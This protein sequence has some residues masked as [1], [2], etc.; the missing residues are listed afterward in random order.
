MMRSC[1]PLAL[2]LLL[3]AVDAGAGERS[4]LSS[5]PVAAPD[6]PV[7]AG[8][9]KG[10]PGLTAKETPN[11]RWVE[12]K[13]ATRSGYCLVSTASGMHLTPSNFSSPERDDVLWRLVESDGKAKLERTRFEL[14]GA[15][16]LSATTRATTELAKVAS[17]GGVTVWAF[18]E[19]SGDVVLLVSGENASGREA[20]GIPR[21]D[22]PG[23]PTV[24]SSCGF[25][26]TRLSGKDAKSGSVALLRASLP[27]VGEGKNKVVPELFF[28]AS[29]AQLRRDPEPLLSVRLAVEQG[30]GHQ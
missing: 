15:T 8:V 21:K 14:S 17:E 1:V 12:I 27:A 9:A 6:T 28:H 13:A 16:E 5:L 7:A 11:G 29:L 2:G 10:V 4:P 24:W 18:R 25:G 22:A 3:V 20:V 30:V 23:L 26:A 19:Q